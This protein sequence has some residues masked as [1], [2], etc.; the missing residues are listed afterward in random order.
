MSTGGTLEN[1]AENRENAKHTTCRWLLLFG[2]RYILI[3]VE[4]TWRCHAG[5]PV[6]QSA[7][8]LRAFAQQLTSC[9]M[10]LQAVADE[11]TTRK[12]KTITVVEGH[13]M[14]VRS[15]NQYIEQFI[16]GARAGLMR[17]RQDR[18]DFGEQRE[19]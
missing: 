6:Q 9:A 18:G 16:K 12:I 19:V 3:S 1:L 13:A 10:A 15:L 5:P 7:E 17:F 8:N 4:E 11:M 2:C 14:A